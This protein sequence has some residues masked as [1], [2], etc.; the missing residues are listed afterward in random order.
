MTDYFITIGRVDEGW[1]VQITETFTEDNGQ[2]KTVTDHRV[3]VHTRHS[4]AAVIAA[5]IAY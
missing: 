1:L 2:D 4:V 5:I 3:V